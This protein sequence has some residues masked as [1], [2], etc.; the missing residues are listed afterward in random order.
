MITVTFTADTLVNGSVRATGSTLSVTD[1]QARMLVDLGVA[2]APGMTPSTGVPVANLG[3]FY[4]P[5]SN[6]ALTGVPTAPTASLGTNTDQISTTAF[7]LA[8]RGINIQTFGSPTSSG[9]FSWTKPEGA[10][11]VEVL[12]WSAG[13]NGQYGARAA[14]TAARSGGSGGGAGGFIYAKINADS[15][16][17]TETVT[18]PP[19]NNNA[20]TGLSSNGNAGGNIN[21]ANNTLFG[22]YRAVGGATSSFDIGSVMF[23]TFVAVGRGAGGSTGNGTSAT[24]QNRVMRLIPLGG[25]GGGGAAANVTTS[26][27]GG[28]GGGFTATGF[29]SGIIP[30][31]AGGAGGNTT[32]APNGGNGV[33]ATTTY[34][35]GGTG[36][37]GGAYRTGQNGGNGGAGG[38]PGGGGGGGAACDDVPG[39][40]S[41]AGGAGA[42]GFAVVITYL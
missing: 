42:N 9:T 11:M 27:T 2:T 15:L 17:S 19:G 32:T 1:E 33:S 16:A 22:P 34:D 18:I 8:N 35:Q 24:S 38:W 12:L 6:A 3:S 5:I 30:A 37:G 10:K 14:T 21:W 23:G 7:V 25:G 26:T 28:S 41:G 39:L 31:T 4:A 36:G 29:D 40:V 20:A 13:N